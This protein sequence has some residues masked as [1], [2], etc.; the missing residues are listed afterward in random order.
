MSTQFP[1]EWYPHL[2]ESGNGNCSTLK[3]IQTTEERIRKIIGPDYIRLGMGYTLIMLI[4]IFV[5]FG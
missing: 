3:R 4:A 5:S 1:K 2:A